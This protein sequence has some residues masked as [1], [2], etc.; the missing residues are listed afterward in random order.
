[1]SMGGGGDWDAFGHQSDFFSEPNRRSDFRTRE[2]T[3]QNP[4]TG[5]VPGV[6]FFVFLLLD[7]FLILSFDTRFFL[8]RNFA[9]RFFLLRFFWSLFFWSL[10]FWSLFFLVPNF[11]ARNFWSQKTAPKNGP[12]FSGWL[13]SGSARRGWSPVRLDTAA[14]PAEKLSRRRIFL[15]LLRLILI[16]FRGALVKFFT[17]ASC[18]SRVHKLCTSP[19]KARTCASEPAR[20]ARL[21]HPNQPVQPDLCIRTSPSSPTCASGPARP[22]RLVHPV[23]PVQ[24]DLCIRSS[25]PGLACA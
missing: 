25:R 8:Q 21:V 19:N 2:Q 14:E 18:P 10:F 24:P 11:L 1:M 4:T 13:G 12:K 23:Q 15:I 9:S 17:S 16:P 3:S 7:F 5:P 22:A 6:G 20:P